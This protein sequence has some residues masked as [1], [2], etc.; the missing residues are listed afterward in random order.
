[1]SARTIQET[2]KEFAWMHLVACYAPG[3]Q[4]DPM[5][6][7]SLYLNGVLRG[8]PA[9]QKGARYRS[10]DIVPVHGSAPLRFGTRDLGSF[11]KGGLDEVA[12]Y[13]RVLS[14][15]EIREH[16]QASSSSRR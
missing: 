9:T 8:S 7:V 4:S 11:L 1:M 10:Y 2:V 3:D 15:D 16:Y 5:A 12:I 14:D 6:G 13:P